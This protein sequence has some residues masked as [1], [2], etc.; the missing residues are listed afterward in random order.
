MKHCPDSECVSNTRTGVP[1]AF[2]DE[3]E[4]CPHCGRALVFGPDMTTSPAAAA[5]PASD[6]SEWQLDDG[7]AVVTAGSHPSHAIAEMIAERLGALGI[8]SVVA[9]RRAASVLLPPID[10]GFAI[11]VRE[12]DFERAREAI[13][14]IEVEAAA[15]LES[16]DSAEDEDEDPLESLDP[17]YVEQKGPIVTVFTSGIIFMDKA[18]T[19]LRAFLFPPRDR[20][21]KHTDP[22]EHGSVRDE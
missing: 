7:E 4:L 16:A 12:R 11:Q 8:P 15:E 13:D 14:T 10:S 2:R 6:V 21:G 1:A 5:D 3:V 18:I 17:D 22:G 9:D 20:S 19:F